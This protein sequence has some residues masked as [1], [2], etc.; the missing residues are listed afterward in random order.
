MSR[1]GKF[2]FRSGF[3]ARL[4]HL[5]IIQVTFVSLALILIIFD[6][7][8]N[9]T[10]NNLAE[11][12]NRQI[13][14]SENLESLIRLDREL[15]V[16]D[17]LSADTRFDISRMIEVDS[18]VMCVNVFVSRDNNEAMLVF[19]YQSERSDGSE[20]M[21]SDAPRLGTE[22]GHLEKTSL[23]RNYE[24]WLDSELMGTRMVTELDENARFIVTMSREHGLLVSNRSH[25]EY[26]LLLIVLVSILIS[27]LTVRLITNRFRRPLSDLIEGFKRTANGEVYLMVEPGGD[28]ELYE[29]SSTFNAM[30]RSLQATHNRLSASNRRLGSSNAELDSSRSFLKTVIENT[31]AGVISTDAEGKIVLFNIRAESDFGYSES[32][33]LGRRIQEL[34]TR[35]VEA[36][37]SAHAVDQN[38]LRREL[39]ALRKDGTPFP[40][41]VVQSEIVS[42]DKG[43]DGWLYM[44][45]DIS[46]SKDFQEMI[47][48]ID[49]YYT[50]GKMAADIA[51]DINNYLAVLSGNLEL[52]PLFLKKG[53]HEKIEKKLEIMKETLDKISAFSAGLMDPHQGE[54]VIARGDINQTVEN[55]VAFLKPQNRFESTNISVELSTEIPLVDFDAAQIQQVLISLLYNASDALDDVEGDRWIKV[56]TLNEADTTPSVRIEIIDSGSGVDD[57][58]LPKLFKKRFSTKRKGHGLGLISSSEIIESHGGQISY[59]KQPHSCFAF[60]IPTHQP[61]QEDRA[62]EGFVQARGHELIS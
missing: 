6:S 9:E 16:A 31:P 48:R 2:S 27:L 10:D 24:W 14:L 13:S 20:S 23:D 5:I 43:K 32:E 60:T 47:M 62:T 1:V 51:H 18:S 21:S 17:S 56:R 34:F 15:P 8:G 59:S 3:L 26:A 54:T 61:D 42:T 58:Q 29:L 7:S 52:V 46:E 41:L 40:V 36:N 55:V 12:S 39:L 28:E 33:V 25:L 22:D 19:S 45:R 4:S 44:I 53:N 11:I 37:G 49:R 30:S 38:E 35:S 57:Q 50:R